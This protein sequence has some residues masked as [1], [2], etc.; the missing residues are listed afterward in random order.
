M[1]W[2]AM[3]LSKNKNLIYLATAL[4]LCA[5]FI[6]MLV[7]PEHLREWW[8]TVS[9]S[10]SPCSRRAGIAVY[11]GRSLGDGSHRGTC[12]AAPVAT[13]ELSICWASWEMPLS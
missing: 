13:R 10:P 11:L 4:S 8:A 1:A 7:I 5:A 3:E 9:S 2:R 12:L 6:H